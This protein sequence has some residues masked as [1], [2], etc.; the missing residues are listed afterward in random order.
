MFFSASSRDTTKSVLPYYSIYSHTQSFLPCVLGERDK[1]KN[2]GET[3]RES[4][5]K[6]KRKK[7][8]KTLN[9]CKKKNWVKGADT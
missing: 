8:D 6:K 3:E 5:T 4:Y 2:E 9:I 7:K 1:K